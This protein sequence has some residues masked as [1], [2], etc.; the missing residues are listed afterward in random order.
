MHLPDTLS[1]FCAS[2]NCPV[3]QLP[4]FWAA[5]ASC[6]ILQDLSAVHTRGGH[7]AHLL[8]LCQRARRCGG[9]D[10]PCGGFSIAR[11]FFTLFPSA[12]D[13]FNPRSPPT[14]PLTPLT[15]TD[16]TA[17][18]HTLQVLVFHSV[19]PFRINILPCLLCDREQC[20]PPKPEALGP[21][22]LSLHIS[23][24]G[25]A[26]PSALKDI[27]GLE[28]AILHFWVFTSGCLIDASSISPTPTTPSQP[29]TSPE[30]AQCPLVG[31][32]PP[33]EMHYLRAKEQNHLTTPSL[34]APD[35]H[36]TQIQ[37]V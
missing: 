13:S 6:Y 4:S 15:P 12:S 18:C 10:T 17:S 11:L 35:A 23:Y 32:I 1:T 27:A 34:W 7:G 3:P 20:C 31:E 36:F 37:P 22:K 9:W 29:K 2:L 5:I 33:F 8:F 19:C 25:P 30:M 21:K 28:G 24:Q 26:L 16:S 14:T